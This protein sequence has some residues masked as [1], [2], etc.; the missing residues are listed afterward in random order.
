MASHDPAID[1]G[2]YE[3]PA[4]A[5]TVIIVETAAPDG[6]TE[7]GLKVQLI[8]VGPLQLNVT[9]PVNPLVGAMLKL[10]VVDPPTATVAVCDAAASVKS[11][12]L[13]PPPALASIVPN[14]P[15]VSPANPAVK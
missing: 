1:R 12:V 9:M 8:P 15:C 7:E 13:P 4:A 2:P 14:K 11:G 3:P 5:V 6:V 10:T